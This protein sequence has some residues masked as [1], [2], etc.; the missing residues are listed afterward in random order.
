L[1]WST[2]AM[3]ATFLNF[4]I[5]HTSSTQIHISN[6]FCSHEIVF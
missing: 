3:M 4:S 2:W 1:P 6:D 5:L